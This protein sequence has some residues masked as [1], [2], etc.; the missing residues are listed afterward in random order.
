[1]TNS[2]LLNAAGERRMFIN[3]QRCPKTIKALDG[4]TYME[5]TML[6]DKKSGLDHASDAFAYLACA[7][8]PIAQQAR[9]VKALV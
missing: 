8:Y 1:M 4:L 3:K 9:R 7:E 6:P 2:A 5:G